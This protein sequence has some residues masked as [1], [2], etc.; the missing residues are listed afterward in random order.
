MKRTLLC[1]GLIFG[2]VAANLSA[3]NIHP[4]EEYSEMQIETTYSWQD[5]ELDCYKYPWWMEM[6]QAKAGTDIDYPTHK[7]YEYAVREGQCR[8]QAYEYIEEL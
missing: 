7:G 6:I 5:Y 8:P 3:N 1:V 4:S 2:M